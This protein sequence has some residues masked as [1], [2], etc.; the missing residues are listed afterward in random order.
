MSRVC[1]IVLVCE[2]WRDSAFARGFLTA[3]GIDGRTIEPKTNPGGSGHDWVKTQFVAEATNLVRFSEGRGVLGL[4][5]EDGQGVVVREQEIADQLKARGLPPLAANNGRCLL[6]P[7]RNIE[8]WLYWLTAQ[9]SG[10]LLSVDENT[11]YKRAGPPAGA[12]RI[13]NE[14]CR[15]AG[16]FL[17][18]LNHTQIPQ[19][20]PPMLKQALERLREF[21][22]AVRR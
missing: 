21:L 7:T 16:E 10:S 19:G 12:S 18:T 2:G 17:H 14:N 1:R 15:P 9:R 6:L 11:D 22:K 20:C 3:A 4:L 8:T 13:T 5:D